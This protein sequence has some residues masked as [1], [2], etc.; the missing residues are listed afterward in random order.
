MLLNIHKVEF[1]KR[2]YLVQLFDHLLKLEVPAPNPL[3]NYLLDFVVAYI[4]YVFTK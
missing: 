1:E 4:E 3:V 2:K